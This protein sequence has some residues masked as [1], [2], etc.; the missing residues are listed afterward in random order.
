VVASESSHVGNPGTLGMTK[1]VAPKFGQPSLAGL[2]RFPEC[3][4]GLR[5]GLLS[6][7]L[8]QIRLRNEIADRVHDGEFGRAE[9]R[10]ADPSTTLRSGRDDN[11]VWER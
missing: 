3:Y 11:S 2:V 7:F 8:V 6:D 9:G 1:C 5:P 10:T 4:P